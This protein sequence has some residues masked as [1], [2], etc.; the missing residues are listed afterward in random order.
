MQLAP[1]DWTVIAV[2]GV[3]ALTVSDHEAGAALFRTAGIN[4]RADKP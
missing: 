3:V 4:F 2:Y 1:L